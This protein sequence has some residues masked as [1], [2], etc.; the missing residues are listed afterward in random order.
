MTAAATTNNGDIRIFDL[1]QQ[2]VISE[3]KAN[4]AGWYTPVAYSPRGHY[5]GTAAGPNVKIW[6]VETHDQLYSFKTSERILDFCFSSDDRYVA[7]ATY[8]RKFVRIWEVATGKETTIPTV[9]WMSAAAALVRRQAFRL[10]RPGR[11]GFRPR[12]EGGLQATHGGGRPPGYQSSCS[13]VRTVAGSYR[14]P[15]TVRRRIWN[16][17]TGQ[18][19]FTIHGHSSGVRDVAFSPD[20]SMLV[21]VGADRRIVTW[22]LLDYQEVSSMTD[23][24][25]LQLNAAAFSPDGKRLVTAT[26]GFRLWDVEQRSAIHPLPGDS[27]GISVAFHP[28]SEQFA[29]GEDSGRVQ[30]FGETDKPIDVRQMRV[31]RW[32]WPTLTAAGGFWSRAGRT[33]FI[34]GNPVPPSNASWDRWAP[35]RENGSGTETAW[36]RSTPPVIGSSTANGASP[37]D[38]GCCL[39]RKSPDS[40]RHSE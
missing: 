15:R 14:G 31:H 10:G 30:I 5:L 4:D 24:S 37:R 17:E 18:L 29:A 8:G 21:T 19:V 9:G 11:P 38:L 27:A 13:S 32:R 1:R 23:F 36:R 16:V 35:A 6:D 12:R 22:D 26:K 2:K 39:S 7:V 34:H 33:P 20:G 28:N 3:W 25:P 40:Q